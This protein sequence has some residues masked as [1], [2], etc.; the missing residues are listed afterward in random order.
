MKSDSYRRLFVSS[1]IF[2][3]VF[4]CLTTGATCSSHIDKQAEKQSEIDTTSDKH[5]QADTTKNIEATTSRI[6]SQSPSEIITTDETDTYEVP[7][8]FQQPVPWE[9]ATQL[10]GVEAP[11]SGVAAPLGKL[12]S[13]HVI[14]KDVKIGAKSTQSGTQTNTQQAAQKT[15]NSAANT[16]TKTKEDDH[17]VADKSKGFGL[18]WWA[19]WAI[20]GGIALIALGVVAY[21][22]PAWL[23]LPAKG[24]KWI[25][26][27]FSK[28]AAK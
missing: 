25:I 7:L 5:I 14:T 4:H 1:L 21:Y 6:I 2:F 27:L 28:G 24:V 22:N 18:P 13:R 23:G 8:Q 9:G 26:G 12:V 19:Y 20:G 17:T 11:D 15:A 10:P 3:S 16:Q